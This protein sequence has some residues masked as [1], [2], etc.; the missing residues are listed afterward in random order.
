MPVLQG[1][2]RCGHEALFFEHVG[3]KAVIADGWKAVQPTRGNTWEL[4]HLAEDRTETRNLADAD[5]GRL[6]RL[7]ER[8]Q[9]WAKKVGL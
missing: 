7:V 5:P 3:G 8:W 9:A 6:S 4:Y 1:G 2:D